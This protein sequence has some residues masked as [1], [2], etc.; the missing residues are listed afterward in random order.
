MWEK[1]QHIS[2]QANC[3]AAFF[4]IQLMI[5]VCFFV[6]SSAFLYIILSTVSSIIRSDNW[7]RWQTESIDC[8]TVDV[9]GRSRLALDLL[10]LFGPEAASPTIRP[11]NGR[12]LSEPARSCTIS[13]GYNQEAYAHICWLSVYMIWLPENHTRL[14]SWQHSCAKTMW[15]VFGS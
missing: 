14:C 7:A 5:V 2:K 1:S 4:C 10:W 13:H 3:L 15:A 6:S 8:L 11:E 12:K 9:G